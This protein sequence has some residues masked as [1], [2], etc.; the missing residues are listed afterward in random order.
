MEVHQLRHRRPLSHT[1]PAAQIVDQPQKTKRVTARRAQS[2]S[3]IGVFVGG[4]KV[5]V[6]GVVA[7][8]DRRMIVRVEICSHISP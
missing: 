6:A 1:V 7:L 5:I 8:D 3:N 2:P 4:K